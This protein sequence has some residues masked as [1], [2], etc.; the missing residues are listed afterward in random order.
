MTDKEAVD[1]HL[2][3]QICRSFVRTVQEQRRMMER[4]EIELSYV[5]IHTGLLMRHGQSFLHSG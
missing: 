3:W 1:I 5:N 4:R 2:Q